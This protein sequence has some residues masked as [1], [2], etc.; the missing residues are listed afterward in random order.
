MHRIAQRLSRKCHTKIKKLPPGAEVSFLDGKP[1]R[2]L[3][4][5]VRKAGMRS[6]FANPKEKGR[7]LRR[8]ATG[9][10]DISAVFYKYYPVFMR[11][12][13]NTS[14]FARVCDL[15]STMIY[16]YLKIVG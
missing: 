9:K 13:L 6:R 2:R 16:K 1:A 14:E 10:D 5:N 7:R 8:P 3:G 11:G 15:S 4:E 12:E